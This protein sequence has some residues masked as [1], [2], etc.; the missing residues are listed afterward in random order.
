MGVVSVVNNVRLE[1]LREAVKGFE[2]DPG[3]LKR[4]VAVGGSWVFDEGRPQFVGEV[5]FEGGV[6]RLESNMPSF[7]GG[8]GREPSPLHYCLYGLAS[9]FAATIASIAAE[10]GVRL[11]R[12]SVVAEGRYDFR[13]TLGVGD[14]PIVEE[15][16]FKVDV[17]AEGGGVDEI[18]RESEERCPA[19]NCL[20]NPVRTRVVR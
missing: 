5:R 14:A 11:K 8:E 10:R 17:E 18:I 2:R 13:K 6:R 12:L 15:V 1:R 7:M 4:V 20:K 16:V 9:C 3:S 19:V